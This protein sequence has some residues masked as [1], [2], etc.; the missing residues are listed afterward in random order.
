MSEESVYTFTVTK[1]TSLIAVFEAA[2]PVLATP[3]ISTAEDP[4]W[5]QIMNAHTDTN[6]KERYIAYDT[7]TGGDYS[8]A[9]RVEKPANQTD[10]FLWRLED[11]GNNRVY[12][13]LANIRVE[14]LRKRIFYRFYSRESIHNRIQRS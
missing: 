6:R 7:N 3:E 9:L 8:T 2:V 12:I 10:K 5:Y 14:S 4:I 11:A 13:E 1:S